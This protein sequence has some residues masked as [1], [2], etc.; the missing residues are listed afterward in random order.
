MSETVR[1][2]CED[3]VV[4]YTHYVDFGDA[5]RV[6]E[7]FT[8]DGVWESEQTRMEGVDEL[9][10][11]FGR[12]QGLVERTSRHVCTNFR[13]TMID[14]R[15]AEGLV[16]FTLYRHDGND[17]PAPLEG[18]LMVGQYR[19]TFVLT[20]DGWRFA[21]RRAEAAFVRRKTT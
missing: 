8:D 18:P 7:L 5:A 19:D 9:R 17:D 10:E 12:R 21:H 11:G 16:Y 4:A 3:L 6:A 2:A 13:L 1:H 15:T 20:E 14:E